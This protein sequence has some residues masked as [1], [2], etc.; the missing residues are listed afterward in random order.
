MYKALD[1]TKWFL[2]QNNVEQKLHCD[3]ESISNLKLQKLL[4]YAQGC[5]LGLYN[6]PLFDEELLAWRHGPVV[7]CI[8][9]EF[10]KFSSNGIKCDEKPQVHFSVEAENVM[11]WVYDEFGQYTA[12]RLRNMTHQEAPWLKTEQNDVISKELIRDYF[13][14]NYVEA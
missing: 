4:Y 5:Y 8:Y 1:V 10:K 14:E 11:K 3:V 13:L 12:W 7:D 2:N 6:E 9:Q